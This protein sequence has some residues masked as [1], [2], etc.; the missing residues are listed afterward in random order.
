MNDP[1]QAQSHRAADLLQ[2]AFSD[3]PPEGTALA[4]TQRP[5]PELLIWA[6]GHGIF[7]MADPENDHRIE[8]F[9][10]DP[11]AI[12]PLEPPD[13]FHVPKNVAREVKHARFEIRSDT[14]FEQVMRSCARDR[15]EDNRTWISEP[16]IE[17]YTALHRAGFAHS[18]EAWLK[19]G[20]KLVG[21]LYGVHIGG[22]FF[23]ESMFSLPEQGGSSASKV[24][25]VHLVN[26]LRTRDGRGFKLLDTQ[27][28]NEHMA[29]FGSIE[30]PA[31][32]YIARL[33]AAIRLPVTWGEFKPID[34]ATK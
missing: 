6:Y 34:F 8:W 9:F 14:A 21:G 10:P 24:C 16:M 28:Q 12:L 4:D 23:G 18:V 33:Y 26:W 27:I 20:D 15:D 31:D 22:A 11:R 29:Q 19:G 5:S 32:E 13:A 17:A 2:W 1:H 3:D 25:L 7:P 30:I